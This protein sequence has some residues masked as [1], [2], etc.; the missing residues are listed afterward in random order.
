MTYKTT[1]P[2]A[3]QIEFIKYTK[4][5]TDF[6]IENCNISYLTSDSVRNSW[7]YKSPYSDE[8]ADN[9]ILFSKTYLRALSS[10]NA[11][12][13]NPQFL[14]ALVKLMADYLSGYTMRAPNCPNRKAA[15]QALFDA[16]YTNSRFINHLRNQCALRAFQ[17]QQKTL[18]SA[19]RNL[20]T[21]HK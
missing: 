8:M 15:K 17:R 5:I 11:N 4:S 3:K 20:R 7:R 14:H 12:N 2:T 9:L 1:G 21:N 19:A 10:S 6:W 16:L 18:N 13:T